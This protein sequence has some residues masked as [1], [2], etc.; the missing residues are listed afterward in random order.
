MNYKFVKIGII[1]IIFILIFQ[2]YLY[3]T[4]PAFK[5]DDSPETTT[6]SYTLGIGHPPSYPLFT[7]AGKIAAMFLPG[8]PAFRMNIFSIILGLLVLLATCFVLVENSLLIFGKTNPAVNTGGTVLLGASYL[9]WNQALEAKGGIYLLNLLFLA[10]IIY[11]YLKLLRRFQIRYLYLIS[12]IFGLSLTDHWPSMVILTPV[13]GYIF[14]RFKNSLDIK[15]AFINILLLAAGLTA[16]IYLPIRANVDGVFVFMAKPDTWKNFIWTVFRSGYLND[17]LASPGDGFRQGIEYIKLLGCNYSFLCIFA[18]IGAAA[19]WKLKRGPAY[20]YASIFLIISV[21]LAV[22]YRAP[23]NMA[24]MAGL[25]SMPA[26]YIILI[27]TATGFY[28]LFIRLKKGYKRG[29]LALLGIFAVIYCGA[30][31]FREN[32]F[33]NNYLSYDLGN[34]II[35]TLDKGSFY[36]AGID[37]YYMPLLYFQNVL[38]AA[39]DIR[40]FNTGSIQFAWGINDFEKK[41][42]NSGL[43][44]NEVMNNLTHVIDTVMDGNTVYFTTYAE[45][46]D[47]RLAQYSAKVKG[48]LFRISKKGEDIPP[49]IFDL[50][51]YRGIY[52]T[53]SEYDRD[54]FYLYEERAAMYADELFLSGNYGGSVKMYNKALLLSEKIP[55]DKFVRKADIYYNLSVDYAYLSDRTDQLRSLLKTIEN[56]RDFWQAYEDAGM[57]YYRD[58]N[59][60]AAM[61]M[62]QKAVQYGSP[63]RVQ[64]GKYMAE[65]WNLQ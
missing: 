40:N 14:Y 3:T 4:Y 38:H 53:N 9:F 65:L 58:R 31:N 30:V 16:Y 51:S 5:N 39:P 62:F 33:R 34:N 43:R 8:S 25:F 27:L 36:I 1:L 52:G 35:K 6:V 42:G 60:Q 50:Y 49:G 26:Q 23:R 17:N 7:M 18:V 56:R 21:V 48:I 22:L 44:E 19:M 11:F 59:G 57:I 55:D 41:Y 29:V 28:Y 24:A 64:L 10:M 12:Y 32:D 45:I 2:I 47:K 54:I 46:P 61:E 15:R 13:F 63:D 37:S 20:F